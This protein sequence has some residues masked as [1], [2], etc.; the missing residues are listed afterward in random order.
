ME[1][2]HLICIFKELAY[3][4][5]II[6]K[7]QV[8][9]DFGSFVQQQFKAM[10]VVKEGNYDWSLELQPLQH[11]CSHV[12]TIWALCNLFIGPVPKH[13]QSQDHHS[14]TSLSVF[15]ESQW[16]SW[17]GRS[18]VIGVSLPHPYTLPS[19]SAQCHTVHS[20]T[21]LHSWAP[22]PTYMELLVHPSL[23]PVVLLTYLALPRLLHTLTYFLTS[24][25]HLHTL[26]PTTASQCTFPTCL[27]PL[28][29]PLAPLVIIPN[30]PPLCTPPFLTL[31]QSLTCQPETSSVFPTDFAC[32]KQEEVA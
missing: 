20:H 9:L 24:S 22:F 12:F 27:A 7:I 11:P 28:P 18:Q 2:R 13:P 25:L 26:F 23:T 29:H 30:P 31:Q 32:G 1:D 15:P 21:H 16:R 17:Q 8:V 4:W 3:F 14:Q 19:P 5:A 10:M 6:F